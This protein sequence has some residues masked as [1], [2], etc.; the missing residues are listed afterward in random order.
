[1]QRA[2]ELSGSKASIEPDPI[3]S[4][5]KPAIDAKV[6]ELAEN[7]SVIATFADQIA[8]IERRLL[9]GED[10]SLRLLL[11]DTQLKISEAKTTE[12]VLQK[13]LVYSSRWS[14]RAVDTVLL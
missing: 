7:A 14:T 2:L 10:P 3:R 4:D 13:Q 11:Q 12:S 1:M 6:W 9:L 5:L 8:R